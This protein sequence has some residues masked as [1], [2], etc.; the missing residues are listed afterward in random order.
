MKQEIELPTHQANEAEAPVSVD[1]N[2][3]NIPIFSEHV[4]E[5]L[6]RHDKRQVSHKKARPLGERLLTG[7]TKTLD[8]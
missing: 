6:L 1:E 4:S 7:L 8:I 3:I 2:L 5:L